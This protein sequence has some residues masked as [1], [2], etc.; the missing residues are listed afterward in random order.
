MFLV[1]EAVPA[2]M[3]RT[4]SSLRYGGRKKCPVF[5]GTV[6]RGSQSK[7]LP[8]TNIRREDQG[9]LREG[10][11]SP[12]LHSGRKSKTMNDPALFLSKVDF[13]EKRIEFWEQQVGPCRSE[14]ENWQC[15]P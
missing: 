11:A 5:P 14:R 8:Q 4:K 6:P 7:L 1:L 10:W 3:R 15:C 12:G 13:S 2:E 9:T